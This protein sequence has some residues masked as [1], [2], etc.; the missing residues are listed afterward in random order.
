MRSSFALDI[1]T[2]LHCENLSC[3]KPSSKTLQSC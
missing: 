2:R 3:S 1:S